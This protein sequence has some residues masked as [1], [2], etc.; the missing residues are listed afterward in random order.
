MALGADGD[1]GGLFPIEAA[2]SGSVNANQYFAIGNGESA[3]RTVTM[4]VDS[5]LQ[6]LT[7]TT[8]SNST[9]TVELYV[10]GSGSGKKV[11]TSSSASPS[12]LTSTS[13]ARYL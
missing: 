11:S 9:L 1:G 5:S 12:T 13:K 2:R 10:N 4:P 6:Y 3:G 8:D 7:L